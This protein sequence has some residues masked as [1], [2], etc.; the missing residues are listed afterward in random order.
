MQQGVELL[1]KVGIQGQEGLVELAVEI[2]QRLLRTL[3]NG[4][5]A[6]E[7]VR[8]ALLQQVP[9]PVILGTD[10]GNLL[11]QALQ[12]VHDI[13][14]LHLVGLGNLPVQDAEL[15]IGCRQLYIAV[16]QGLL[17]AGELPGAD[18]QEI[19]DQGQHQHQDGQQDG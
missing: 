13:G 15:F 17:H 16:R 11:R 5:F 8:L 12:E 7:L 1:H 6:E 9:E 4:Q 10:Q 2:L 14:I 3:G 19:G 18:D